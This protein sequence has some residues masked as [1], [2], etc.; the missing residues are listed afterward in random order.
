MQSEGFDSFTARN[1]NHAEQIARFRSARIVVSVHG[2]GLANLLFCRRGTHV[3][4]IFP[5]DFVKSTYWWMAR[6]LSLRYQ[7]VFG[8]IGDYRQRVRIDIDQVLAALD[9]QGAH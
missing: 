3:I 9:G 4:E 2:S 5:A 6:R 7:P 8:G 1:E